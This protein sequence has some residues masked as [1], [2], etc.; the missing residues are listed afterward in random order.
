MKP[1]AWSKMMWA[2]GLTAAFGLAGL[3]LAGL[4]G[5]HD[6]GARS[7][8]HA[9][10]GKYGGV[11]IL[12]LPNTAC[13]TGETPVHWGAG[14]FLDLGKTVFD[15]KTGLE[16]EKKTGPVDFTVDFS[17]LHDVDNV[18]PWLDATGSWIAAVNAEKFAGRSDWRVPTLDELFTILETPT[19]GTGAGCNRNPCID[20][21]FGPTA[22]LIYWSATELDPGIAWFV[23]FDDSGLAQ[24]NNKS[25]FFKVR[26]VRTGP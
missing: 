23:W 7:V 21:I 13:V 22:A 15:T 26:A 19:P 8:V 17:N 10:V 5:A 1:I 20:P 12:L 9:C 14:R 24:N 11:R 4:A 16:W 18:Y 2:L 25:N 3:G 6:G